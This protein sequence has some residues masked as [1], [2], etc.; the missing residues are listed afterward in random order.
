MISF[1]SRRGVRSRN[2]GGPRYPPDL[3]RLFFRCL[4]DSQAHELWHCCHDSH[5]C[6]KA[7]K[8]QLFSNYGGETSESATC[9]LAVMNGT[10]TFGVE[11]LCACADSITG[12]NGM[13]QRQLVCPIELEPLPH[14]LKV[15]FLDFTPVHVF[16]PFMRGVWPRDRQRRGNKNAKRLVNRRNS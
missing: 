8:A 6:A 13:W 1:S 3:T 5:R 10:A 9:R 16:A 2:S 11:P 4:F 14:F 15:A 7:R 12:F